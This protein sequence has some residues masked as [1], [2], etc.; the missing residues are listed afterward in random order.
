MN[1]AEKP[2]QNNPFEGNLF[3]TTRLNT[4]IGPKPVFTPAVSSVTAPHSTSRLPYFWH[5]KDLLSVTR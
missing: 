3:P 2:L 1:S 4:V 5:F